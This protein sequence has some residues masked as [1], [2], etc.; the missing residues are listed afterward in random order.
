MGI[1]ASVVVVVVVVVVVAVVVVVV[2]GVPFAKI[3]LRGPVKIKRNQSIKSTNK[4]VFFFFV[5]TLVYN[6]YHLHCITPATLNNKQNG[7][8]CKAPCE[9]ASFITLPCKSSF[10]FSMGSSIWK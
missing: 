10:G 2:R 6:A 4:S 5:K 9:M 3:C 8:L 1:T 7:F